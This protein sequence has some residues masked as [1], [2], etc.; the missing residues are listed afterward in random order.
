MVLGKAVTISQLAD[1]DVTFYCYCQWVSRRHHTD[2]SPRVWLMRFSWSFWHR[3]LLYAL[4]STAPPRLVLMKVSET[5]EPYRCL[6]WH[7]FRSP[8]PK[9]TSF[10]DLLSF[11]DILDMPDLWQPPG[12]SI[13]KTSGP[14]RT[15]TVGDPGT[16]N[17]SL[18]IKLLKAISPA[19]YSYSKGDI[20]S[21]A[22][23]S[24]P[25]LPIASVTQIPASLATPPHLQGQEHLKRHFYLTWGT[26]RAFGS[27]TFTIFLR[28]PGTLT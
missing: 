2:R 28:L 9:Q 25:M 22:F 12:S 19:A 14:D 7:Q 13:S 20:A 5:I 16:Q 27:R 4:A 3:H 1:P 24:G 6:F 11:Y 8:S 10:G 26:V 17:S 18:R 21:T 23:L 15:L